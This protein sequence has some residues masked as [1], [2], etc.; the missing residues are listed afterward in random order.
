ME[1]KTIHKGKYVSLALNNEP[2]YYDET[3][4]DKNI[5]NKK[6][7][8][9]NLHIYF[10]IFIFIIIIFIICMNYSC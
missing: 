2:W 4:S 10:I 9:N 8:N 1:A 7:S 6:T 5:Q 3:F